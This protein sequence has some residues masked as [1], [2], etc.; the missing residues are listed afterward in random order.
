M[1]ISNENNKPEYPI[2]DYYGWSETFHP[3]SVLELRDHLN[4]LIDEGCGEKK[5]EFTIDMSEVEAIILPMVYDKED[6]VVRLI[7][8]Y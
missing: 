4:K 3:V 5:I 7:I 6:D 8:P 2:F 1:S